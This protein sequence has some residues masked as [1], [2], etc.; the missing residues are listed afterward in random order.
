VLQTIFGAVVLA[1]DEA[2][3]SKLPFYATG[4]ALVAWAIA[5]SVFGMRRP[6]FPSTGRVR[7]LVV[8]LTA[9]LVAATMAGALAS[10]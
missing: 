8:A 5:L 4:G 1:A 2:E 10:T 6:Q 7:R 9:V 3:P